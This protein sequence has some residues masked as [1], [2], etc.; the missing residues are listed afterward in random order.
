MMAIRRDLSHLSH[1]VDSIAGLP[2]EIDRLTPITRLTERTAVG[3][4]G[5]KRSG[6]SA[7]S[8]TH[9][10]F[11]SL[12]PPAGSGLRTCMAAPEKWP[13]GSAEKLCSVYGPEN[14]VKD[15]RKNAVEISGTSKGN[16]VHPA[17]S[18]PCNEYPTLA[19]AGRVPRHRPPNKKG[20]FLNERNGPGS[21][22]RPSHD[23]RGVHR[24]VGGLICNVPIRADTG[25][26]LAYRVVVRLHTCVQQNG[27]A[28]Q[29]I[30]PGS[31]AWSRAVST[32]R[33][34]ILGA[35]VHDTFNQVSTL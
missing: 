15:H 28:Q 21:P 33:A 25:C 27:V 18:C 20:P 19:S 10:T 5:V 1:N 31:R 35:L 4:A 34:S 2:K 17:V 11:S 3:S 32:L 14:H 29:V 22:G 9:V 7:L 6:A 30:G 16:L 26:A 12:T 23:Q 13:S 24:R 8:P